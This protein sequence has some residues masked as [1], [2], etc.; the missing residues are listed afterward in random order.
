MVYPPRR[1]QSA[2]TYMRLLAAFGHELH[3]P[4]ADSLRDGIY[5]LRASHQGIPYRIL[6]FLY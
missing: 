4:I 3:R 2:Y 5:E 6:Y 1:G